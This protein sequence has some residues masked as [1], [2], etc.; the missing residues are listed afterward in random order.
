MIP[1]HAFLIAISII[2]VYVDITKCAVAKPASL[3]HSFLIC[4]TLKIQVSP[5][6]YNFAPHF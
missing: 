1:D 4:S 6:L 2:N 5:H 3:F